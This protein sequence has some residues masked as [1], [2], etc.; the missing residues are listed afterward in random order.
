MTASP[1]STVYTGRV[2][3]WP[4]IGLT[5]ALALVLVSLSKFWRGPWPGMVVPLAIVV[6]ALALVLFTMSSV[7]VTTGPNGVD[8]RFGVFGWPRFH[9]SLERIN[10]FDTISVPAWQLG[11]WGI[12]WSPRRGLLLI[13]RSGPAL[14]LVLTNGRKVT[15]SV[16]DPRTALDALAASN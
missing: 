14:R 9:Y 4:L 11:G 3:N 7:R 13:L 8:A 6:L 2:T 16:A 15:I 12:H 1:T 10:A 5:V